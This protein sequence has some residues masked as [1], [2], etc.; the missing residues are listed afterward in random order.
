MQSIWK[1]SCR[2]PEREGLQGNRKTDV[3]VIGGGMTGILTAFFLQKKG[4]RVLV[5][6]GNR[7][8]M[9]ATGDTTAKVTAGHNLIYDRLIRRMGAET[10]QKYAELQELAIEAYAELI[11]E[12]RIA[13]H[14]ERRPHLIYARSKTGALE[15]E[16]RA[17][18]KL[19]LPVSF[20]DRTELPFPV[21]GAI[22]Y[23]DQAQFHPLEFLREIAAEVEVC[24]NTWV[25]DVEGHEVRTNRGT[26]FAGQIVMAS[27]Y[28]FRNVPGYYFLREYQ[29]KSC[30]LALTG[31]QKLESMYLEAGTKGYSFRPYGKFLLLGG[32]GSRTGRNR[33]GMAALKQA[34]FEWYPGCRVAASWSNQDGMTPDDLPYVG[35]Y[36]RKTPGLYVATGY[37]K[38][39]MT[40]AMAAA[41]LLSR[42]L[43]GENWEYSG[44]YSPQRKLVPAAVPALMKHG[45]A[46]AAGLLGGLFAAPAL[47]SPKEK[48]PGS[49]AVKC[50]HLGCRLSWNPEERVYECPCHG[51][52]FD[53][54]GIRLAGPARHGLKHDPRQ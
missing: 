35:P 10:A 23:G 36:S 7:I 40:Q 49:R 46:S 20:T 6:E 12:R 41:L 2:L 13:C 29:N 25:R 5:L 15:R 11:R 17:A 9:G 14:W 31:A 37:A 45:A 42:E 27:H 16:L 50:S 24:E 28:P 53:E 19:G 30:V 51:S 21:K 47:P 22:R 44:L 48:E 43:A 3:A 33:Q 4:A 39:G 18:E 52:R 54:N 38:W 1:A 26:V 32:E 8:G 34:A